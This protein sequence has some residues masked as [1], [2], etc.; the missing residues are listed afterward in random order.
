[1]TRQRIEIKKIANTAAR[2][3]TFSK[4]RRGLFKKAHEL[5]TLCDAEIALIVFSATGKLF[6]YSSTSMRQVIERHRLQSERIDGL[7]GAPSVELQLES[8]THSVLSK[9]IAEKTQELRQLRGEDLHGLNLDQLK[10]LEKLVQ[11]GLSQ[12]T[13]T[14][15]A[16]LKE[17]NLIL[18]QQ[19]ENLP[20]VVKGQP[21]EPFPH[22]HKSGDPPPPPQGYNTSDISLTLGLPFPS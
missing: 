17:E 5:S 21:S 18:K 7:E 22:L 8:A 13:E 1:M 14:K 16:E 20:L 3:V 4:R 19:V 2:Q 6:K 11:G 10:Q 9:E 12:I 15:G